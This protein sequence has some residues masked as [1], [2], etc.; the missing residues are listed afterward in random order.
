MGNLQ[1]YWTV[2][3]VYLI[4]FMFAVLEF[5]RDFGRRPLNT[6]FIRRRLETG[7]ANLPK[8]ILVTGIDGNIGSELRRHLELLD[9]EIV[10]PEKADGSP[11]DLSS[12]AEVQ[13]AVN[14][15]AQRFS[16]IGYVICNAGVMLYPE[17][18]TSDGIEYHKAV[19][20]VSHIGLI[21]G[22][23]AV[24]ALAHQA[25]I[26]FVSSAT[27]RAGRLDNAFTMLTHYE[28]GYQAYADSKLLLCVAAKEFA[29]IYP[30]H[31]FIA[32]HPGIVPGPLYRHTNLVFRFLINN[33]L[34]HFVRSPKVAAGQLL[35][36]LFS[37]SQLKNGAYY[38][39]G[40]P[41]G[42]LDR[43]DPE[44]S[45]NLFNKVINRCS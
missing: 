23:I 16:T 25:R 35:V 11:V 40:E 32:A 30:D 38:E 13:E 31:T 6:G 37:A 44:A 28:S 39:D 27:A 26:L 14:V 17:V 36:M 41:V 2:F 42:I 4:G 21:H 19:N 22:L 3:H 18:R 20:A 45:E 34:V 7:G 24:G 12:L 43:L 8:R 5:F 33:V 1:Y 9:F 10:V 29:K 15:V